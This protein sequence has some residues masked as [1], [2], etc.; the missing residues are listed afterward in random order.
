MV[1]LLRRIVGKLCH[2]S[3]RA[4]GHFLPTKGCVYMLHDISDSQG[5]FSISELELEKFLSST[6]K[7]KVIRLEE[8]ENVNNFIA[9]T[10]D[11]VPDSFYRKGFPLFKKY[12]VPFTIFVCT[13]LLDTPGFITTD[14]LKEMSQ[15]ELCT[16]G[17]HGTLHEFYKGLSREGKIRF[18][19]NSKKEL[20]YI[21]QRQTDLFAFPYGSI[22]ACGFKEKKL[23]SR[24]YK[25]G[26]GTI[27][28]KIPSKSILPKYFLPRVNLTSEVIRQM[29]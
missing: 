3:C 24:Y 12:R 6:D 28:S 29:S 27:A 9:I 22:Y 10:I 21:C 16:V 8:W 13:S 5:E 23:V 14:Q 25:Y 2:E 20:S 4:I 11:D 17:S 19:E 18:L 15:S 26:F 7:N 1:G